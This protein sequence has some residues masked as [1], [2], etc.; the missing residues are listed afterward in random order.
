MRCP[1]NVLMASLSFLQGAEGQRQA[2]GWEAVG[3]AI[4][5]V[6]TMMLMVLV[7]ALSR[8]DDEEQCISFFG[9]RERQASL[10]CKTCLIIPHVHSALRN[11]H[12]KLAL[13]HLA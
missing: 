2:W 10:T 9:G 8:N 3:D 6:M 4:V 13:A 11:A 12:G 1:D 5:V 7:L